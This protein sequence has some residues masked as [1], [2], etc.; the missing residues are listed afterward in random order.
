MRRR[1]LVLVIAI[2]ACFIAALGALITLQMEA[3]ARSEA[4]IRTICQKLQKM[5]GQPC[6]LIAPPPASNRLNAWIRGRV[7]QP[8]SNFASGV[9][10]AGSSRCPVAV[11]NAGIYHV[12]SSPYRAMVAEHNC[13]A[14]EREALEAGYRPPG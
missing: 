1:D 14:S 11:S 13:F 4:N 10:L 9:R 3:S 7:D 5:D 12:R 6:N 2:M 8:Q